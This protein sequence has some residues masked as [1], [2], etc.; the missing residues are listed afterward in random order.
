MITSIVDHA[1]EVDLDRTNFPFFWIPTENFHFFVF[2]QKPKKSIIFVF[3]S[4]KNGQVC[5][6][7]HQNDPPVLNFVR[8]Y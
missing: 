8:V 7:Q 1:L 2:F 5:G 3:W 6:F 4:Q